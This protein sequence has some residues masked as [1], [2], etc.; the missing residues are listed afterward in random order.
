[1]SDD[2]EFILSPEQWRVVRP[3]FEDFDDEQ[4]EETA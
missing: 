4:Q 2:D 1:M 3:L